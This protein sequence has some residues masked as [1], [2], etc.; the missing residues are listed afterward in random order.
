MVPIDKAARSSDIHVHSSSPDHLFACEKA[1]LVRERSQRL[2]EECLK[3]IEISKDILEYSKSVL[4][5]T[6]E[7]RES[8]FSHH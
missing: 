3:T 6:R 4:E 1:R 2:H 8:L 5:Q 7:I